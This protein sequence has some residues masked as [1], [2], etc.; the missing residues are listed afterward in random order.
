MFRTRSVVIKASVFEGLVTGMVLGV[1]HAAILAS[2]GLYVP[3]GAGEI[4]ASFARYAALVGITGAGVGLVAGTLLGAGT[5]LRLPIGERW[6]VPVLLVILYAAPWVAFVTKILLGR[7]GVPVAGLIAVAAL[8]VLLARFARA[9]GR[10][11]VGDGRRFAPPRAGWVILLFLWMALYGASWFAGPQK[12]GSEGLATSSPLEVLRSEASSRFAIRST[13]FPASRWNILLLTVDTL[14]ADHLGCYGYERNTSPRIDALA[15]TGVRFTHALCQRPKTSPSFA[16]LF[17]GTYPARHGVHGAM[18]PLAAANETLAEYLRAA[19]WTTAAV[20]TNGNL[21]PVYDFDQGFDRYVFGHKR[22]DAGADLAIRWLDEHG[23]GDEPWFLWIHFTDPHTPY[24]PP[25]PHDTTFGDGSEGR[26]IDLYDGEIRYTDH[27]VG[28]ILDWLDTSGARTRTLIVFT[29]DH[30]ESLGEHEYYYSHGLHPYEPSSRVPLVISA[31]GV[32]PSGSVSDALVGVVDVLPT[33]LDALW[34]EV[35]DIVQGRSFLPAA[36]GLSDAGPRDFV[37]IEA[38]YHEHDSAGRTRALRRGAT[39]YVQRLKTWAR[40]PRGV[41][42]VVWSMDARLEGGLGADELY[43][44]AAD[45]GETRNLVQA[46][47]AL[48]ANERRVL[49]AFAMW[50][51]AEGGGPVSHVPAVLDSATYRSLKTLG[52][53]D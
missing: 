32:I 5:R 45:P 36:L 17:T 14:R 35:P 1:G 15:E 26:Q 22:A 6:W 37:F 25:P 9:P 8:V 2:G 52:Y 47:P 7:L 21:Y 4:V 51:E 11:A 44:L 24:S 13:G 33:V 30:G 50:L 18:Q 40:A 10:G 29:A 49:G 3:A 41:G 23:A 38:G 27:H 46:R 20:I 53:I 43:D 19:G 48:A 31:P 34:L 28:K 39:K 42:A 16:T 12:T